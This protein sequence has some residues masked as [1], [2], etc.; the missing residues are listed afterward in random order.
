MQWRQKHATV[1][2][3]VYGRPFRPNVNITSGL[4]ATQQRCTSLAQAPAIVIYRV[5]GIEW[6]SK[7]LT[8]WR[9][10]CPSFPNSLMC[11]DEGHFRS[12]SKR[13]S[14]SS[15]VLDRGSVSAESLADGHKS[16]HHCKHCLQ[17]SLGL[18][19]EA[20]VNVLMG[21]MTTNPIL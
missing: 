14:S 19:S 4:V 15:G 18:P 11:L 21:A 9:Q 1:C 5:I 7:A 3:V 10:S 12:V 8:D 17:V 6:H 13:R 2:S 16:L 20:S